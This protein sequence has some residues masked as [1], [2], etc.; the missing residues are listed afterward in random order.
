MNTDRHL[1]H[2]LQHQLH[3]A[4]SMHSVVYMSVSFPLNDCKSTAFLFPTRMN[5]SAASKNV[6]MILETDNN[7]Q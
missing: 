7:E 1:R 3:F 5:T 2:V 4:I 6:S